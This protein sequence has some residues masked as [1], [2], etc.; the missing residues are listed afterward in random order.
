M[1]EVALKTQK[2]SE[3]TLIRSLIPMQQP[4]PYQLKKYILIWAKKDINTLGKS[5]DVELI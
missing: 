4:P 2:E 3:G 5:V 1:L